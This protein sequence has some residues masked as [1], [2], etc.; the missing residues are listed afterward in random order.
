[1]I[2]KKKLK[3]ACI[4]TNEMGEKKTYRKPKIKQIIKH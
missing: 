4:K 1:M 2:D 3:M